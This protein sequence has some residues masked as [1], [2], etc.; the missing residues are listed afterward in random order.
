VTTTK[1]SFTY[2]QAISDGDAL[3]LVFS[4]PVATPS[5]LGVTLVLEHTVTS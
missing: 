1:Q 3:D 5:D 4:S 2:S